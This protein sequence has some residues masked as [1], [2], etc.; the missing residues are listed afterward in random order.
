MGKVTGDCKLCTNRMELCYSHIIPE[1]IWRPIYVDNRV[2]ALDGGTG[3]KR[4]LQ[5]GLREYMLCRNCEDILQKNESWF[6]NYWFHNQP[7]PDPAEGQYVDLNGID[8]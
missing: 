1:F 3:K 2:L 6:A 8:F 4:L 7:L 5:K